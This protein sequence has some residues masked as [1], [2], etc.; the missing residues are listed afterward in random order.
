[1]HQVRDAILCILLTLLCVYVALLIAAEF[2]DDPT[3]RPGFVLTRGD[4]W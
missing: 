2:E 3:F 1:M 4:V